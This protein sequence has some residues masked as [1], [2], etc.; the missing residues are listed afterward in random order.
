ML[1]IIWFQVLQD[2]MLKTN[3]NTLNELVIKKPERLFPKIKRQRFFLHL[4]FQKAKKKLN[5]S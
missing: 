2:A 4:L 5:Y 3:Y 1:T